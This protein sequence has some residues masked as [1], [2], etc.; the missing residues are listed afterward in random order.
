MVCRPTMA[1]L[2]RSCAA[3]CSAHADLLWFPASQKARTKQ[4]TSVVETARAGGFAENSAQEPPSVPHWP[5]RQQGVTRSFQIYFQ[6]S[7]PGL[8][9]DLGFA[10]NIEWSA[11]RCVS[12]ACRP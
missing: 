10:W 7:Q 8:V 5:P 4:T 3:R 12:T 11:Q 6:A 1:V 2:S 9:Q